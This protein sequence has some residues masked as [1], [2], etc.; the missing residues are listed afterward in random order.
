[1][2]III[3]KKENQ[4]EEGEES[5]GGKENEE[6][7]ASLDFKLSVSGPGMFLQLAHLRV[8]QI[9]LKLK[10]TCWKEQ[11]SEKW[12]H[13]GLSNSPPQLFFGQGYLHPIRE[14]WW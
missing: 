13:Q 14:C 10:I 3:K 1:M 11:R 7:F 4:N 12:N 9:Y 5:E 2:T 8:F 6:G